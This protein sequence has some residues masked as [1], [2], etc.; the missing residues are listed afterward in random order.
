MVVIVPNDKDGLSALV[1]G[2]ADY[3]IGD[4]IKQGRVGEI[5]VFLPRFKIESTLSLNEILKQ[6]SLST[7]DYL[8]F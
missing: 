6:V 7:H 3:K 1:R 5:D 8:N 4:I 2:L